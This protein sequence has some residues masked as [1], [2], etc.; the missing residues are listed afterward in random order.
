MRIDLHIHFHESLNETKVDEILRIVQELKKDEKTMSKAL[1]ALA[2]QVKA[3]TDLE[4]S[5][6]SLI[7]G[8]SEQLQEA[9]D[10][11]AKIAELAATLKTSA[12]T[13]GAAIL[14]NTP[15]GPEVP[16]VVEPP[17]DPP[18]APPVD[19]SENPGG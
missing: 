17:A 1:E 11:P 15:A 10:D 7:A 13:L 3:N 19:P 4:Q 14:A 16:P 5:A 6:I 2:A 9:K 12:S 18:P 8:I